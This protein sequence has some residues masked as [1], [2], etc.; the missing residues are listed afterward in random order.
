[1]RARR[2]WRTVRATIAL[3]LAA[4]P[5]WALAVPAPAATDLRGTWTATLTTPANPGARPGTTP[6]PGGRSLRVHVLG[7]RRRGAPATHADRHGLVDR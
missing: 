3:A 6:A 2:G 7:R 1:M 4:G 5:W